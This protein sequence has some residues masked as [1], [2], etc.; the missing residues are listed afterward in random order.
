MREMF[1][2]GSLNKR[3]PKAHVFAR[4]F[5]EN[6]KDWRTYDVYLKVCRVQRRRGRSS[7]RPTFALPKRGYVV[8]WNWRASRRRSK[9]GQ[10]GGG[11]EKMLH[12][13]LN[14]CASPY[15]SNNGVLCAQNGNTLDHDVKSLVMTNNLICAPARSQRKRRAKEAPSSL[16]QGCRLFAC[17]CVERLC[18]LP[19]ED[20][21]PLKT[22]LIEAPMSFNLATANRMWCRLDVSSSSDRERETLGILGLRW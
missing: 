13:R 4:V 8:C 3:A 21:Y 9:L 12:R 20:V 10:G 18:A 2:T 14:A 5:G 16:R 17:E 15:E 7:K 11:G 22:C 6:F 19:N 1:P